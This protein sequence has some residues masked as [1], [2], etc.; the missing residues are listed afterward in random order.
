MKR[1]ITLL[2]G[3]ALLCG[4]VSP[5][6]AA[7]IE[8]KGEWAFDF[9]WTDGMNYRSADD[10]GDSEDDFAAHQRLRTQIDIIASESLRGVVFL[11]MGTTT[12]GQE[13]GALGSDGKSVKVRRSYIDWTVPNTELKVRMGL[14]GMDLPGATFGASPILS[15]EDVAA[16]VLS[17]TVS[18][19]VALTAFWARPYDNNSGNSAAAGND[20][21]EVDL[22]GL[23]AP[24][25]LDGVSVT[26]YVVYASVGKDVDGTDTES[27]ETF[28]DGMQSLGERT[29]M[30]GDDTPT[31][32]A[33]WGGV[34]VE[35]SMFD[36]F[37]VKMDATYGRKDADEDY[38]TREGWLVSAM[39]EYKMESATPG[40]FA[41]Y[42]SGEDDDID[43][44]S[45]RMPS[46]SPNAWAPTSFGFPGSV[47]NQDSQ[48][49]LNGAGLWGI[50]VQVADISFVENLSHLVRVAYMRG[51]NDSELVKDTAGLAGELA[52]AQGGV[53]LTDKDSAWEV[54][55]DHTYQIYEN[56]TFILEMG[57]IRLDLDEDVWG[58]DGEDLN[59]AKKLTFNLVYE[60]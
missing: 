24:V 48:F 6:S 35:L 18:E 4:A 57:Y 58:A 15:D 29:G 8:A 51:T 43:N 2:L 55:F 45:E 49:A 37:S 14:Q 38:A 10:G 34:A 33:W 54:N 22:F 60:F 21:D 46:V 42:G 16:L 11:E 7:T 5:A 27:W 23:T 13:D 59:A 9:S 52:P 47:F 41:W 19:N 25:T 17:Y 53:F 20:F 30:T 31:H 32:D 28:R 39:V 56:L 40:V 50:G 36:P 44:G 12:W 3:A 1:L 26:P